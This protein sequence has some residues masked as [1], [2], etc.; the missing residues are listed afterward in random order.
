MHP[1]HG[2]FTIFYD[3]KTGEDLSHLFE[4]VE[5]YELRKGNSISVRRRGQNRR[6]YRIVRVEPGFHTRVFVRRIVL[7]PRD[8]VQLAI[9]AGLCWFL[10]DMLVP[11]F[12]G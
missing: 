3:D 11:F 10:F 6:Y 1:P 9:I 2:G 5:L 12:L 8:I 7:H 4:D